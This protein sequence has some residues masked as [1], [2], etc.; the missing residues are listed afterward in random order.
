MLEDIIQARIASIPER[1]K[2]GVVKGDKKMQTALRTLLDGL[3]MMLLVTSDDQR[4][5]VRQAIAQKPTR[6]PV[7][8]FSLNDIG[9]ALQGMT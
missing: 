2:M 6:W 7:Q 1:V 8:V 4:D 3:R 9:V 5:S